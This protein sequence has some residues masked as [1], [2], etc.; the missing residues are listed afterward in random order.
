MVRIYGEGFGTL[1]DRCDIDYHQ[2]MKLVSNIVTP[3]YTWVE[4][5]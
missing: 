5:Q 2:S 1:D 4:L 3:E